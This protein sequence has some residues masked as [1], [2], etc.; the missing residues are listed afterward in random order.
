MNR[1]L[2][3]L[4]ATAFA[5]IAMVP[6]TLPAQAQS[7]EQ[8]IKDCDQDR[9]PDRRIAG[10]TLLIKSGTLSARQ[11][12]FAYNSR[13]NAWRDKDDNERAIPDYDEAIRLNPTY[14]H[15]YLGR[16]N[17]NRELGEFD[18]AL[19]D[20]NE[21][22]RLD[23]RDPYIYHGRANVWVDRGEFDRA[24]ADETEALNLDPK[25]AESYSGRAI[26]WSRKGEFDR[27]L[28]DHDEAI[29][30]APKEPR[31][32]SSR[33]ATWR[34]RGDLERS[35][36]DLN[37]AIRLAPDHALALAFRGDTLRYLGQFD[38][39]LA[40]YDR[41]LRGRSQFRPAFVG[42]GLTYERMNDLARARAEFEKAI[43][44]TSQLKADVNRS[45]LETARA[46]LAAFASGAPQPVIPAAPSRASTEQSIPTPAIAI[47]A[48]APATVQQ[49]RRVALIIGN[50]GYRN[51]GPLKNPQNDAQAIAAS[52]RRVGFETVSVAADATRE[53]MVE[54]LRAF[55]AEAD[56]AEWAVVYYSGH[57][58]EVNG[59]NYLIPVDAKIAVDRDIQF[60]AV[61]LD[62]V[63]AVVEGASKLKLVLLDACRDNPF[64]SQMK[65]TPRPAAA[66][67]P[68]TAGGTVGT[69]SVGRGLG[70]VKVSGAT[71]VVYAAKHGQTALDGEG[72]NSPFAVAMVQRLA[73]PNVEI[74][75]LFRL[76]RDDV[77]EATAGR[78]EPYTYGSLPGRE[79]FFFV[80]R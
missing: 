74:N 42:K 11:Q 70:A 35:L 23:P 59:M 6:A 52:L 54:V 60:E 38:R 78:Q 69:R 62:Q 37:Q 34:L 48:A 27:A 75:K 72:N 33:G 41:A 36:A 53:K 13:G 19:A 17:A 5:A 61:P 4:V 63:M 73:T 79:D 22:I 10:C 55:R 30:L 20:Y 66:A 25:Y 65:V 64:A 2:H 39:A 40:D 43:A 46:R 3:A 8:A 26:A 67:A 12:S 21:A 44:S 77:M 14:A 80:Q 24:I 49:G 76:V 32:L 57:G 31:Y 51:A 71:L 68:S 28:R 16:G 29:R 47:P 56:K 7:R 18:R 15:P 50:A 45:A 1:L 58:M 9:D